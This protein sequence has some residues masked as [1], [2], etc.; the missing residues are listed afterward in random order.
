MEDKIRNLKIRNLA[1][2][3]RVGRKYHMVGRG[4]FPGYDNQGESR[5]ESFET[6]RER[7]WN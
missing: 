3:G 7:G 6:L 4:P 1:F 2:G 5:A